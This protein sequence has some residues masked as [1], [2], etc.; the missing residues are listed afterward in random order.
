MSATLIVFAGETPEAELAWREVS[1]Q[2]EVTARGRAALGNIRE[3]AQGAIILVLP[4]T[5]VTAHPLEL[6]A[7]SERQ[8]RAA[9]PYAIEDQ[10]ASELEE[11]HVALSPPG[12]DRTAYVVSND[13]MTSWCEALASQ[14]LQAAAILPD[15]L[16]VPVPEPG[17]IAILGASGRTLIRDGDWGASLDPAMSGEL[18]DAVIASRGEDRR[19]APLDGDGFDTLAVCAANSPHTLLQGRY[20]PRQRVER[21]DLSRLR[22]AGLLA[23]AA[24]LA[25]IAYNLA[26]GVM[27]R[28]QAEQVA[29]ETETVFLEAFPDVDR[30][31]NPRAQ[32]RTMA[33]QTGESGPDFLILSAWL[34]QA[35]EAEPAVSVEAIRYDQQTG[36]LVANVG[37]RDYE[38]LGRFRGVIEAAGGIVEEGGS[39]QA[40]NDT[41]TGE[42]T[43]RRP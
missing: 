34:T 9:A 29:A 22:R 7:R 25:L 14:D 19:L 37:F 23:A 42:I 40:S 33:A 15:Y 2:G 5:A 26:E 21:A 27:L 28:S 8:A 36:E 41:R 39:R 43:V 4:G 30:V 6:A 11:V 17:E 18:L 16:A 1:R 31:V 38:A 35:S 20:A 32:L 13:V 10:I 12:P 24:A 3:V